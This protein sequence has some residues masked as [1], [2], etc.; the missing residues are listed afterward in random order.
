MKKTAVLALALAAMA[1]PNPSFAETYDQ[2]KARLGWPKGGDAKGF[3][4]NGNGSCTC[5]NTYY[6]TKANGQDACFKVCGKGETFNRET[7]ECFCN[8]P[9][10]SKPM[11]KIYCYPTD[12]QCSVEIGIANKGA[13]LDAGKTNL[14]DNGCVCATG[15]AKN[16]NGKCAFVTPSGT[17]TNA[18]ND[19]WECGRG[20]VKTSDGK[21]CE[22]DSANTNKPA[23]NFRLVPNSR[24]RIK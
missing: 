22:K 9:G 15:Y 14:Y 8:K 6:L 4:L 12:S 24:L 20:Y 7:N 2:C 13:R 1:V 3:D 17:V 21:G 19:G 18:T 5:S 11:D 16:G 23:S 10:Y